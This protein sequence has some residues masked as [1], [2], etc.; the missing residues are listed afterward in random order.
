M[1]RMKVKDNYQFLK[2]K[3]KIIS[4]IIHEERLLCT[5]GSNLFD[6]PYTPQSIEHIYIREYGIRI[7]AI[8]NKGWLMSKIITNKEVTELAWY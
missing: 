7:D 2:N 8:S 1:I 5:A 3:S 6:F 4:L